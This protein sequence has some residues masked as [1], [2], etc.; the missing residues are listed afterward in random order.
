MRLVD[1]F[2]RAYR[3]FSIQAMGL[4]LA[5]QGAWEVIPADMKAGIPQQ[6][7]TWLTLGLLVLG[8]A[9]RLVKQGEK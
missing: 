4:A 8:I 9:G 7:V 5:I 3:W 6:Y 2:K 1:D